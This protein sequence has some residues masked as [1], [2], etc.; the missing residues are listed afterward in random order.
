MNKDLELKVKHSQEEKKYI[1][2]N[3]AELLSFIQS[4]K[5]LCE[6]MSLLEGGCRERKN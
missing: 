1:R 4:E 6:K 3:A 5:D 2:K